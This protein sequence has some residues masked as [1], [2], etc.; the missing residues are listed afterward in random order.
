MGFEAPN[1]FITHLN[2][3]ICHPW[4]LS[5]GLNVELGRLDKK[6]LMSNNFTKIKGISLQ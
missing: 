1:P 2:P 3:P 5:S 4:P 6:I